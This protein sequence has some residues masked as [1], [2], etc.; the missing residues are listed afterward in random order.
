MSINLDAL[1]KKDDEI[2]SR[3][4][5]SDLYFSGKDVGEET[6]VRIL[7]PLPDQKGIYFLEQI[8]YWI[9]KR[10]YISPATF[11]MKC[12]IEEYLEDIAGII[13]SEGDKE[14]EKLYNDVNKKSRFVFPALVLQNVEF[15]EEGE[16]SSYDVLNGKPVIFQAGAMQLK[17]I[18]NVVLSPK[19]NRKLAK[20]KTDISDR[21]HGYN[22][23]L[24]KKGEKLDT[25]YFAEADEQCEIDAKYYKSIPSIIRDAKSQIYAD[26]YLLSMLDHYFYGDPMPEDNAKVS[27]FA[28]ELKAAKEEKSEEVEEAKAEEKPERRRPRRG[29]DEEEK[30]E[31]PSRR[32][33]NAEPD[34][35]PEEEEPEEEPEEEEAP[36]P[37]RRRRSTPEPEP[38]EEPEEEAEEEEEQP[39]RRSRRSNNSEEP[40]SKLL[41]DIESLDDDD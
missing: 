3:S 19:I 34:P 5:G 25:E 26:E 23:L 13:E 31:R 39:R 2:K 16:I 1:R 22:I 24:S 37:R 27:V 17:A 11:G 4:G 35:E 40:K 36:A 9:N 32:R 28:E 30:E 7:P 38:E 12:P 6:F 33:R 29:V 10:F 14:L 15:D 41:D 21:K 8:G 20:M 18:N